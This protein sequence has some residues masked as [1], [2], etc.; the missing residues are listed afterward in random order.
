MFPLECCQ[1]ILSDI[2]E[3]I[4]LKQ[5]KNFTNLFATFV[6]LFLDFCMSPFLELD[7]FI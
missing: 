3:P 6:T 5:R 7:L 4:E 2:N 1:N